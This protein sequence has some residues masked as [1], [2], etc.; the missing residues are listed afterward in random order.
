MVIL[1][2]FTAVFPPFLRAMACNARGI[3]ASLVVFFVFVPPLRAGVFLFAPSSDG[4]TSTNGRVN[5]YD[6]TSGAFIDVIVPAFPQE[7]IN[8]LA[9]DAGSLYVSVFDTVSNSNGRIIRYDFATGTLTTLVEPGSGGLFAPHALAI[10]PDGNLYVANNHPG[11]D[12]ILRFD[13]MTGDFLNVFAQGLTIPQDLAFGPDGNLYV[14]NGGSSTISRFDG[15]TGAAMG[16]FVG[17]ESGGL[18]VPTGIDFGP[19]GHLYVASAATGSVLR[20]DSGNG[21][22]IDTF[23]AAGSGGLSWPA[24]LTFGPDGNLYVDS[25]SQVTI[26]GG[27]AGEILRFNGQTGE[28]IDSFVGPGSGGL[29]LPRGG[30]AFVETS[31]VVPEASSIVAWLLGLGTLA[32]IAARQGRTRRTKNGINHGAR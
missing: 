22:F 5:R 15:T 1:Q 21:G 19:D 30:L 2:K 10:G 16:D 13:A 24:D 31:A 18:S 26:P 7:V 28:F 4:Q 17:S 14:S 27:T 25:R 12:E 20:Y 9:F 3:G 32:L 29:G 8:G 11:S 23:V 6:G